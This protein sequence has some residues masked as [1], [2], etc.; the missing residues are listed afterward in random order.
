MREKGNTTWS[1]ATL[2]RPEEDEKHIPCLTQ[3]HALVREKRLFLICYF[4]SQDI[5]GKLYAD[6]LALAKVGGIIRE[7]LKISYVEIILHIGSAHIYREDISRLEKVCKVSV[8]P[9]ASCS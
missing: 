7:K 3:I 1:I 9:V 5:G 2:I 4:R 8:N 6:L